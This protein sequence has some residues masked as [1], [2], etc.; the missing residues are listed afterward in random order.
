MVIKIKTL[1]LLFLSF[2]SFLSFANFQPITKFGDNPGEL[3]ASYL[4]PSINS[5]NMVV[6]LHGCAQNGELLA[7]QS[8]FKGLAKKHNFILL[9]P[10]QDKKNNVKACFNWFSELDNKKN[11]GESLS[12]YNMITTLKNQTNAKTVY[13]AGVSAGGAM[14]SAMLV[15]YPELFESGAVI[16]GL[17]YPCANNLVK[18][19]SCMRNGPLQSA[20]ELAEHVIKQQS[21]TIKWP[22]LSIWTGDN[23]NVV[24]PINSSVLAKQW[25]A[26]FGIDLTI[27]IMDKKSYRHTQWQNANKGTVVELIEVKNIGHGMMVAPKEENGGEVAPFL[28]A[29]KIS[30]AKQIVSFWKLSNDIISN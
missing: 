20:A 5:R 1:L 8:G 19:I 27:K 17:P 11:Q 16:A 7:K 12:L 30:S 13:I 29:T 10:Q 2:T 3:S 6:L 25:Q 21:K 28:L 26:L 15:N 9:I 14:V 24:N 18:A 22:T 23:D 4:Q